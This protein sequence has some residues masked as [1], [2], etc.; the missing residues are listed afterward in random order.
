M[1]FNAYRACAE[2]DMGP[3]LRFGTNL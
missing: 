3:M 2:I 1:T